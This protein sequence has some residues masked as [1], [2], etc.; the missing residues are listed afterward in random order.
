M[1][2]I[3]ACDLSPC[4]SSPQSYYIACPAAPPYTSCLSMREFR[5]CIGGKEEEKGVGEQ[6]KK[7]EATTT[8]LPR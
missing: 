7:V 3:P 5:L 1:K 2:L 8:P 4:F 6:W